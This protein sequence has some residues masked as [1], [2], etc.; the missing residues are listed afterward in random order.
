M[1]SDPKTPMLSHM[2]TIME[3]GHLGAVFLR[4]GT[5]FLLRSA[6]ADENA[7]GVWVCEAS[8]G[9]NVFINEA[10]VAAIVEHDSPPSG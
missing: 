10:E 1:V 5:Q 7:P 3:A 9:K 6:K 4:S 8:N 2:E